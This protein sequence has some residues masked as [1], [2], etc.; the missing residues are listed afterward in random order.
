MTVSYARARASL[1][2]THTGVSYILSLPHPIG[3]LSCGFGASYE[4][5]SRLTGGAC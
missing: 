1:A 4:T 2:A 5:D 3:L